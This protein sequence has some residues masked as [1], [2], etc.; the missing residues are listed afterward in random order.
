MSTESADPSGRRSVEPPQGH[1]H[2][3][4]IVKLAVVAGYYL[5]WFW[6]YDAINTF[7]TSPD[8]TFRLTSPAV[9]W[10][11]I[12][13]PW[14]AV[15]YLAG[16][17]VFPAVPFLYHLKTWRG[18]ASAMVR[19]SLTSLLSFAIYCAWPLSI[20]RPEFAG[21]T[22]GERIMLWVFS[23]DKAGNCFPSSHVYFSVLG[24][25]HV[26]S[27]GAGRVARWFWSLFALAVCITTVT[28]GQHYFIDIP[29][30]VAVAEMGF[31]LGGWLM[32][33]RRV[34]PPFP[35]AEGGATQ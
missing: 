25:L 11:A 20:V 8:R 31:H 26:Y 24:A 3:E 34:E 27:S 18:F 21:G 23:V 16:G 17:A 32:P 22:L 5:V 9:I 1:S 10:P 7:V 33:F 2:T 4:A 35:S 13:Q 15:I 29:A 28:T 14:T 12:I 19:V 30:G 6:A